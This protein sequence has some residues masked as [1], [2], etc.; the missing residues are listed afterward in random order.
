MGCV[1]QVE[2]MPSLVA[3]LWEKV[4]MMR[5][6]RVFE[7]EI[8]WRN[9]VLLCLEQMSQPATAQEI[10]DPLRSLYQAVG[11]DLRDGR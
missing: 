5:T 11:E 10:K 7:E 6:I 3:E 4:G 8:N 1:L 9:H 2:V